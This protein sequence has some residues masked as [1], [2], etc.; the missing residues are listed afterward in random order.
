MMP[1]IAH[2]IGAVVSNVLILVGLTYL[3]SLLLSAYPQLRTAWRGAIFGLALGAVAGAVMFR[4]V[5]VSGNVLLD[6]RNVVVLMSALLGGPVAVLVTASITFAYRII[7]G[8]SLLVPG[9]GITLAVALG[10][11]A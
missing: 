11:I 10:L 4:S 8:G 1:G 2:L 5:P 6:L 7:L 3:V 9:I